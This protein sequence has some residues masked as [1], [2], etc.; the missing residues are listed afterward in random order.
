MERT[1]GFKIGDK[2]KIAKTSEY[3][4]KGDYSNPC[5]IEGTV[6]NYELD[7]ESHTIRV[8]WSN[9]R[10]NVYRPEDLEYSRPQEIFKL[11]TY[12]KT[13]GQQD[14]VPTKGQHKIFKR[15]SLVT[16]VPIKDKKEVILE[17]LIKKRKFKFKA[18]YN[19]KNH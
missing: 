11:L 14:P 7:E 6:N 1:G 18:K 17:I 10:Y 13:N 16:V 5:D 2:V 12:L 3:Y 15:A 8:S 4:R 19:E 9:G